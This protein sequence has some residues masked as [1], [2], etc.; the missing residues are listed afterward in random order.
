MSEDLSDI[1][2][3]WA[4]LRERLS[5]DPE[6]AREYALTQKLGLWAAATRLRQSN[7]FAADLAKINAKIVALDGVRAEPDGFTWVDPARVPAELMDVYKNLLSYG[8]ANG[9]I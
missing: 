4:D 1:T 8:Y 9:L 7:S 2:G 6:F 3:F 5:G